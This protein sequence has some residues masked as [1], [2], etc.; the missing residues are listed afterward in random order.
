M[1]WRLEVRSLR[2]GNRWNRLSIRTVRGD[3]EGPEKFKT[4]FFFETGKR[5]KAH[6]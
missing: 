2:I 3:T 4:C 6:R 5:M 1:L